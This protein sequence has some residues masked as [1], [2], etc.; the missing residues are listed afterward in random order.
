LS[1]IALDKKY[2]HLVWGDRRDIGKIT[3]AANGQGGVQAYYGRVPFAV[4]SNGAKCG[5]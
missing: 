4:A 5:R 2:A 3:N 1:Y